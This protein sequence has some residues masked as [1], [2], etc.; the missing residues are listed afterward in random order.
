[1]SGRVGLD[2]LLVRG[3]P[4]SQKDA[5]I[6][7]FLWDTMAGA[8]ASYLMNQKDAVAAL[9][10]GDVPTFLEKASPIKSIGDITKAAVG[11]AG[12]KKGPSGK[13]TQEQFN[14][15]E[16]TVRALGFTPSSASELGAL[17]GT[18]ARESKRLSA[19]RSELINAWIDASGAEKVKVQR[20]VQAFNADHPKDEQITPKDLS[21]AAK[22]RLT[23][24]KKEEHGIV[25]S[26]RTKALYDTAAGVFNP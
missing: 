20:A 19:N 8:S 23:E 7:S 25:T 3:Q 13:T 17:R 26:K 24:K 1:M 2:S 12:E 22:R 15:W 10:K 21:A 9:M 14:A 11:L 18:H 6:K 5:D 4:K 16:A